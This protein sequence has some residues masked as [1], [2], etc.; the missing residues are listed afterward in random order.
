MLGDSGTFQTLR[1][2]YS[3]IYVEGKEISKRV[4]KRRADF[5]GNGTIVLLGLP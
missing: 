3:E 5:R 2:V 4:S 1:P